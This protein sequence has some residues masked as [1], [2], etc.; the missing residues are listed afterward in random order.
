MTTPP[1]PLSPA[2]LAVAA[3]RPPRTPDAPLNPPIVHA[4]PY[5]AGGELGYG[6]YGNPTWGAFEEALAALDGGRAVAFASGTAATS[7]VLSLVPVGG[8]VAAP[9]HAYLGTLGMLR[10]AVERHRL[11]E[12]RLVDVSDSR[13]VTSACVGADLLWLEVP[14]N[15]MLEVADLDVVLPAARAA[16]AATVIDETFA[17]PLLL[18]GLEAGA[19]V[20]VHSATK[21]LSGHSD[22]LLGAAV[23]SEPSLVERLVAHRS[24]HGAI[25]GASEA[26]LALRGMRTLAL[27]VERAQANADVLAARLREHRA[28]ER[29]R[30]PGF[31]AVL[32]VELAAGEAAADALCARVRLWVHATSLGG[33]ESTL[34]RRRRWATE[35]AD[36]PA[37]L[38]RMA[39]GI[40]DVEDLWA[41][42]TQ[43]LE[44]G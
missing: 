1:R 41:D 42:L 33:V 36:V 40:E 38:V 37:S 13:S 19:D 12:V 39:V 23:A 9:T 2:T 35:S 15:P 26:W 8:V 6:R 27:R 3:G 34:E 17:T 30:Y 7:A 25:P 4:A 16:G 20:V 14:A 5:H 10:D 43:A 22:V 44:S 18:R 21:F 32:S 24:L 28:V 31:G 29:V 11:A